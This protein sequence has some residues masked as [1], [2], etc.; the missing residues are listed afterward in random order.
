MN[1][2]LIDYL[3]ETKRRGLDI[4]SLKTRLIDE[5]WSAQEIDEALTS[6]ETLQEPAVSDSLPALPQKEKKGFKWMLVAGIIGL[7][8]LILEIATIVYGFVQGSSQQVTFMNIDAVIP[9]LS[10]TVMI[11]IAV[12]IIL[13]FELFYFGFVK[14]GKHS[15]S[16]LLKVSAILM[17]FLPLLAVADFFVNF[18]MVNNLQSDVRSAAASASSGAALN[19]TIGSL[20]GN[21][22]SNIAIVIGIGF[23]IWFIFQLLFAV[24]LIKARGR[25][26]FAL[27]SGILQIILLILSLIAI[28]IIAY[29]IL[30]I[31]TMSGEELLSLFMGGGGEI[32]GTLKIVSY[33]T[34]AS[35]AS[36]ILLTLFESLALF[37]ASKKFE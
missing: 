35:A 16:G 19:A 8:F 3:K 24:G 9:S 21:M 7:I 30:Q 17:M 10:Y 15:E 13:V 14:M 6:I 22:L 1:Q 20:I 29:V 28:A 34:Y 33:L 5:G 4:S 25:V 18:Q 12:A 37:D 32:L 11:I 36:L 26:K 23:L 27:T 2:K 31:T